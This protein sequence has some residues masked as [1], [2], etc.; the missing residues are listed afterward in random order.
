MPL[1]SCIDK[2]CDDYSIREFNND[3]LAWCPRCGKKASPYKPPALFTNAVKEIEILLNNPPRT[4]S[5]TH[6]T[7]ARSVMQYLSRCDQYFKDDFLDEIKKP[8]ELPKFVG[9]STRPN[10]LSVVCVDNALTSAG[11]PR[12]ATC[13]AGEKFTFELP[14]LMNACGWTLVNHLNIHTQLLKTMSVHPNSIY[15]V[16]VKAPGNPI[17]HMVIITTGA[18]P[19]ADCWITDKQKLNTDYSNATYLAWRSNNAAPSPP[20]KPY[21]AFD[22][23]Q[24][25]QQAH[26][27]WAE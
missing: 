3:T 27:E 21:R 18:N 26:S 24:G 9:L 23:S 14:Y 10:G 16:D 7:H 25:K 2:K 20:P 13:P 4:I 11:T 15:L 6:K 17:S 19:T 22:L 12:P 5:M 8:T 1:Y